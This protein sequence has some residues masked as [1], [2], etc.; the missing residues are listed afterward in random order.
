MSDIGSTLSKYTSSAELSALL[1]SDKFNLY[2]AKS[3]GAT[4][5]GVTDD[6]LAVQACIDAASTGDV[7]FIPSGTYN[8]SDTITISTKVHFICYGDISYSGTRDRSALYFTRPIGRQIKFYGNVTD[9]A[10]TW[11]GWSDDDYVG[12]TFENAFRCNIFINRVGNFTVGVR[13]LT[14]GGINF[15]FFFNTFNIYQLI[16][17]RIQLEIYQR[18][19]GSWFNSN[20]FNDMFFSLSQSNTEF[21]TAAVDRYCIKQTHDTNTVPIDSNIFYN[22]RFDIQTTLGGTYTGI[23]LDRASDI[24]FE[25]YRAELVSGTNVKLC[26]LDIQNNDMA[27]IKFY[28][29]Y[30]SYTSPS[31]VLVN[32]INTETIDDSYVNIYTQ[33]GVNDNTKTIKLHYDSGWYSRYRRINADFSYIEGIYRY[34]INKTDLDALSEFPYSFTSATDKLVANGV[35]IDTFYQGVLYLK[36]ISASDTITV[37]LI[38]ADEST[39]SPI[40]SLKSWDSGD[41]F[42]DSNE[43]TSGSVTYKAISSDLLFW[44]ATNKRLTQTV[45][46]KKL[47]FTVARDEVTTI[48]ILFTGKLNGIEITSNRGDISVLKSIIPLKNRIAHHTLATAPTYKT[49]GYYLTGDIVSNATSTSGANIGWQLLDT[50]FTSTG[51]VTWNPL[52][53]YP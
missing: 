33:T 8:I 34:I 23:Y 29:A 7:I 51:T 9:Q 42:I 37:S 25:N 50:T 27:R 17:N 16:D 44:D 4:G 47:T 1:E 10:G 52:G 14:A 45:G 31:N 24:T 49:E 28:P 6:T 38:V 22:L 21:Q 43:V 36:G 35:N 30:E 19:A 13:C 32:L 3:Y 11:H 26:N 48:A 15:G 41:T 39:I 40:I 53:L 2:T 12:I 18:D 5:D 46:N 20:I